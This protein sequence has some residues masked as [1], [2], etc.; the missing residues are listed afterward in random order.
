VVGAWVPGTERRLYDDGFFCTFFLLR[1]LLIYFL[2]C[3]VAVS[4]VKVIQSRNAR[5]SYFDNGNDFTE[6][7]LFQK[8]TLTPDLP[9]DYR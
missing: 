4:S 6:L 2:P 1:G 7:F 3:F 9:I 8:S 5:T